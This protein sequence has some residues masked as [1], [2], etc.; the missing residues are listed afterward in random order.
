MWN[1][2]FLHIT[3][4]KKQS[5]TVYLSEDYRSHPKSFLKE[6]I[7]AKFYENPGLAPLQAKILDKSQHLMTS[8]R[9]CSDPAPPLLYYSHCEKCIF[10]M[11]TQ[12][13]SEMSHFVISPS[14]SS[15]CL[16]NIFIFWENSHF[17]KGNDKM[18]LLQPKGLL[19]LIRS[20]KFG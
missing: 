9:T 14:C 16:Q 11:P 10:K 15:V 18:N 3:K 17:L 8:L 5:R 2:I 19:M 6:P 4:H 7:L 12:F 20:P 1:Q 13:L